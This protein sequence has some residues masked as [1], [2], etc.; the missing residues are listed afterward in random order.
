MSIIAK[1]WK[2]YL[3]F[4]KCHN[5]VGKHIKTM[6]TKYQ[7]Q[8]RATQEY[9]L[10]VS[11][12][13]I[14]LAVSPASPAPSELLISSWWTGAP[15]CVASGTVPPHEEQATNHMTVSRC[16]SQTISRLLKTWERP[17]EHCPFCG[18]MFTAFWAAPL[19]T[20]R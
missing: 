12:P 11:H 7:K 8:W 14:R 4:L 2:T 3:N 17:S 19:F 10:L 1:P 20:A 9:R 16:P 13:R 15:S 5:T 18:L 6:E